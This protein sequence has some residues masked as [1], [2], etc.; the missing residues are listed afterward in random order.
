MNPA[1]MTDAIAPTSTTGM[2][3]ADTP[4]GV[5]IPADKPAPPPSTGSS[6]A[7]QPASVAQLNQPIFYSPETYVAMQPGQLYYDPQG[8]LRQKAGGQRMAA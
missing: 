4:M 2:P 8:N 3:G 1:P 5:R 6:R 7:P